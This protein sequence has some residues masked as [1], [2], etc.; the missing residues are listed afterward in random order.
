M[1]AL[2]IYLLGCFIF[3][4]GYYLYNI[5]ISK[6]NDSKKLLAYNSFKL[7]IFSWLG[8]IFCICMFIVFLIFECDEYI[9]DKLK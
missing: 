2:F 5:Y 3:G 6:S 9:T 8:I 1:G 4:I 7:S